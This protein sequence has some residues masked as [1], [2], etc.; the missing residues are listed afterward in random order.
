VLRDRFSSA[1]PKAHRAFFA[2]SP[3]LF[4]QGDYLF[5]HAGVDPN[6]ALEDQ[7]E[8]D[9]LWIRRGFADRDQPFERFVIHGHTPVHTPLMG[10]HRI[11]LDTG[12][13]AT[14]RLSCVVLEGSERRLLR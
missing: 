11:N 8:D 14:G 12:A 7:S 2:S 4:D 10:R 5:V 6:A 13:F 3:L 1:M 9:L